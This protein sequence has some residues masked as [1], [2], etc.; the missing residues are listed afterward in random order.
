[1]RRFLAGVS[2]VAVLTTGMLIGA[3]AAGA[4][5]AVAYKAIV[6]KEYTLDPNARTLTVK[7]V[8][9]GWK[10]YP[11]LV[12]SKTNK[13]DGGHWLL[14]VN[15]KALARSATNSAV[16]GATRSDPYSEVVN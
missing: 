9:Y 16:K 11:A 3:T 10:M 5:S 7:V 15:G 1:M 13:P 14:Y 8:T 4:S 6:I 12:G 2:A